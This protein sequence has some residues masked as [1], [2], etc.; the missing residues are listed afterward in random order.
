MAATTIHTIQIPKLQGSDD[1]SN[2]KR[3]IIAVLQEK[4][5]DLCIAYHEQ[6]FD[7]LDGPPSLSSE[8]GSS[9]KRTDLKT[10]G[11]IEL[12]VGDHVLPHLTSEKTAHSYWIKLHNLYQRKSISSMVF[13]LRNLLTCTQNGRPAQE[14][15][16][17]LENRARELECV[18]IKLTSE[19]LSALVICNLDSRFSNV[20]TVLDTISTEELSLTKITSLLMNE[21]ARQNQDHSIT[22]ANQVK[23]KS[24][25]K[26]H[27]HLNHSDDQCY[28]QHPELR[29]P[30]WKPRKNKQSDEY[31]ELACK[32][33]ISESSL[34]SN[35][36]HIDTGCS[37]HMTF[38]Q[39]YL[40]NFSC[41]SSSPIIQLGDNS[42]IL[43]SGVGDCVLKLEN[44][45]IPMRDVLVVPDL[46]KNLF[47]PG[48][49]A[50]S[51]FKFLIDGE[52]MI[53]YREH[54]FVRPE[55]E[56]IARIRKSP[57]NLYRFD[58][59]CIKSSTEPV[60]P[61]ALFA[62]RHPKPLPATLWHSR[63]GH[64][65]YHDIVNMS[66]Q[67]K[68]GIRLLPKG[69]DQFCQHCVMGKMTRAPFKPVSSRPQ[70]PGEL[71]VS[72][73][74]GPFP[75]TGIDGSRY[76]VT[77]TDASSRFCTV[78]LLNKKSEQFKHLKIFEA[79]FTNQHRTKIV[80]FQ[81][82]NGGEYLSNEIQDWFRSKGIQ[83]RRTVPGDS[84]SNGIAERLNRTLT[85]IALCLLSNS[86]L[87]AECFPWAIQTAV[88][89]YNRRPHS[90][91]NDKKSPYQSLY[92]KVPNLHYLR[93]FGCL[94]YR[95]LHDHE[96]KKTE[97][98]CQKLI[99]IG[100]GSHQKAYLLYDPKSKKTFSS[101][102]AEFDE[103]AF[104]FGF[105]REDQPI[106]KE[107]ENAFD[108]TRSFDIELTPTVPCD[109]DRLPPVRPESSYESPSDS[110]S[111]L[112][113]ATDEHGDS[114]VPRRSSRVSKPPGEWWK[115]EQANHT[116]TIEDVAYDNMQRPDLASLRVSHIKIPQNA[117]QALTS[118]EA[119]HWYDAMQKEFQQMMDFDT[120]SLEKLPAGRKAISSK[121][122]FTVKP[123]L[124]GDGSIR[125]FKARLV[126]KGF[127]QRAGID[128]NET[129]APVAHNQSFRIILSLAAH[130]GLYLRQIDVVGAFLNG[131]IEE[132]IYMKQPDGFVRNGSEHLVC[133]LKKAL[134]GLKQ[135]GMIWNQQ[136]DEFI[137]T[138]LEF[139]RTQSD[140]CLYVYQQASITAF[141]LVHVDDI[142]I[143]HNDLSFCN[144]IADRLKFKWDITDLGEPSRILGMHL[145]RESST[146]SIFIHQQDYVEELLNRF[147]MKQCK[148]ADTPHQPGYYL[149]TQMSPST[150][151]QKNDM[152]TVPYAELV[153]SLNWL[154]TTTRPDIAHS[155]GT[156]CRFISNPGRQHWTAAQRVLRYLSSTQNF[157]IRFL[158]SRIAASTNLI[159][160]SDAD[161]AGDP[162]TRRST[163]G[164]IFTLNGAP[165][166]WKSKLQASTALSS[167]ESEYIALCG[168]A[169]EAQWIRQILSELGSPIRL[170]TKIYD[171]NRG[172]IS[173][174]GN[175]RTDART[176]H[177]DVKYHFV[178]QMVHRNQIV[179]DYV[180]TQDMIADIF[181]KPTSHA[182]FVNQRC[183]IV[184][185]R[186]M[187]S[188][189]RAEIQSLSLNI[190]QQRNPSMEPPIVPICHGCERLSHRLRMG[191][192]HR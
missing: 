53:I 118:P 151:Q 56:V 142:M 37:N 76:F 72:D 52:L 145:C 67:L 50:K 88:H 179:I 171:D 25:C 11:L 29:P 15:V 17:M 159:G 102:D 54:G 177:I 157:G 92:N 46:G 103:T 32:A 86:R 138:V 38:T 47:S 128:Y 172:C 96:R 130:H 190:T 19:L 93:V 121:W 114:P 189:G 5:Y 162:D 192:S 44:D 69:G 133:K 39:D 63:L 106:P 139:R 57:D 8:T 23:S 170:P 158:K 137:V 188:R 191:A 64:T 148:P 129:F 43:S 70:V 91:L 22:Q 126:I 186:D 18:G 75:T 66:N 51:G 131:N 6:T 117:D 9:M 24:K 40:S 108:S 156:L 94:A 7:P 16:G 143:A 89:I 62:I 127:S 154:A 140:P 119:G 1:F 141:L 21:E 105:G 30:N 95:H 99:H 187:S 35:I 169:R 78:A 68:Y 45:S 33:S 155:V 168:A 175:N 59:G 2:W 82:D 184:H 146:G 163:T 42:T 150:E 182:A 164:F 36:W 13:R 14:Y 77:Y 48:Q 132:D 71:V 80:A 144:S 10:R 136:L 100:Y 97:F 101:R 74:M 134:Y 61:Q 123:N 153:G 165:I 174:S 113:S 84:E 173:I 147:N 60:Y 34:K 83:H 41:R 160:F 161:W 116:K 107:D 112:H 180:P 12:N 152:K 90:S 120:W 55:G 125:K 81:T 85:D 104:N 73:L 110:E 65:N 122:V 115:V 27:P 111:S 178:R 166:S 4:D 28:S 31:Y 176:K 87:P 183:K 124:I 181:T 49:A 149:T 58:P 185:S 109:T 79:A 3:R 98:R 26:I 167:V 135:A 20:A